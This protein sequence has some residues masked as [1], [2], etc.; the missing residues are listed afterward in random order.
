MSGGEC[1]TL[2]FGRVRVYQR[3]QQDE[4]EWLEALCDRAEAT[5]G[6]KCP[7]PT[8][9]RSRSGRGWEIFRIFK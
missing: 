5:R 4:V 1:P 9:V 6:V 3:E 8:G 7:L 2:M